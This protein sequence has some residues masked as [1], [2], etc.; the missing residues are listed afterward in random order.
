MLFDQESKIWNIFIF[1]DFSA[2][3]S[4]IRFQKWEKTYHLKEITSGRFAPSFRGCG[5]Y[6][7]VI[8]SIHFCVLTEKTF[9]VCWQGRRGGFICYLPAFIVR[10]WLCLIMQMFLI[11]STTGIKFSQSLLFDFEISKIYAIWPS[12]GTKGFCSI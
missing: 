1:L 7:F 3:Y 9:K 4:K 11:A 8:I 10:F 5:L 2:R 12:V 6:I